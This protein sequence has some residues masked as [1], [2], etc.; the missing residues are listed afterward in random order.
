MGA[1]ADDDGNDITDGSSTWWIQVA[2]ATL[3][4]DVDNTGKP[5]SL[6]YYPPGTYADAVEGC[7]Y[8]EPEHE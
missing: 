7:D 2:G 5:T 8:E 6:R 3:W 4:V 1:G